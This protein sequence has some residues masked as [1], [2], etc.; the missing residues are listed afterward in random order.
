[1]TS[2]IRPR[3]WCGQNYGTPKS[4][5]T[6]PT[7]VLGGSAYSNDPTPI[8]DTTNGLVK[9]YLYGN[10]GQWKA[11]YTR[12]INTVYG[13]SANQEMREMFFDSIVFNNYLQDFAGTRP[14]DAPKYDYSAE[15]HFSAFIKILEQHKPEVIICW[16][17]LAWKALRDDWGYG[18]GVQGR[19]LSIQ[20]AFFHEYYRFPFAGKEILLVHVKHPSS[21]LQRDHYHKIFKR[22]KLI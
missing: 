19:P 16:G 11:T 17:D 14:T 1:M 3:P 18:L 5:F 8:A 4:I 22:L 7:F 12:F 6:R 9:D 2:R 15:R 13:D 21:S 10:G 20:G